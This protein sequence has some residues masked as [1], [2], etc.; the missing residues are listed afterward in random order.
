MNI[1]KSIWD[2]F[3]DPNYGLGTP[4]YDLATKQERSRYYPNY[5]PNNYQNVTVNPRIPHAHD[6]AYFSTIRHEWR[7]IN[8]KPVGTQFQLDN[9]IAAKNEKPSHTETLLSMLEGWKR[10]GYAFCHCSWTIYKCKSCGE[11]KHCEFYTAPMKADGT[12]PILSAD[13]VVTYYGTKN[14]TFKETTKINTLG[15][16]EVAVEPMKRYK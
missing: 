9:V 1:L 12:G 5:N 2:F 3:V 6:W 8:G 16:R 11:T 15:K 14:N 10:Q 13:T 4:I 7:I